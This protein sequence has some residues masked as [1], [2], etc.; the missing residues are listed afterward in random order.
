MITDAD[1]TKLKGVFA[2][3]EDLK[4]FATK[5]DLKR[6]ATKEDLKGFATKEDLTDVRVELGEMHDTIDTMASAIG[7]IENAL[8]K[9]TGAIHD[10]QVENAAGAVHLARHDRQI[11]TLALATHVTLLD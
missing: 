6:F 7:R 4:G 5:E 11:E 10:Q 1:I 3:K 2:T 8:D 9:F